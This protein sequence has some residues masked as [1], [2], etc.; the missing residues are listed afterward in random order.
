MPR[1]LHEHCDGANG[2]V[3]E[4][5]T[6]GQVW[7]RLHPWQQRCDHALTDPAR[8]HTY[9][10]TALVAAPGRPAVPGRHAVPD[11]RSACGRSL[12]YFYDKTQGLMRPPLRACCGLALAVRCTSTSMFPVLYQRYAP[13]PVVRVMSRPF[14]YRISGRWCV[15]RTWVG[16]W[17]PPRGVCHRAR[18]SLSL[19]H[20]H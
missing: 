16:G 15:L 13:S 8:M 12:V 4:R 7:R 9:S 20:T 19:S 2:G 6:Q 1:R 14:Q 11:S 10:P 17:S 5:P 3:R 18:I